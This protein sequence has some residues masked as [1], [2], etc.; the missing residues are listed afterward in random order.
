MVAGLEVVAG[1]EGVVGVVVGRWTG[2]AEVGAGAAG[3]GAGAGGAAPGLV[4]VG[5]TGTGAA[6]AWLPVMAKM[7]TPRSATV[8]GRT[9][10][11]HTPDARARRRACRGD[12]IMA[13]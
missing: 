1:L 9:V 10:D 13:G 3:A 11:M 5:W 4:G 8:V 12:A 6:A 7:A 2:G